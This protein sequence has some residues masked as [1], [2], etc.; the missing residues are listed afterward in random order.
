MKKTKTDWLVVTFLTLIALFL[1]CE[2]M[3]Q[4]EILDL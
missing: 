1:L 2:W 4:K 3:I